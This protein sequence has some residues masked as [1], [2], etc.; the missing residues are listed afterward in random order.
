FWLVRSVPVCGQAP[1]N[2]RIVGG[3]ESSPGSWPWIVSIRPG[4][5]GKDHVCGGSLINEQWVL[6]ADI[7]L[8]ITVAGSHSFLFNSKWKNHTPQEPCFLF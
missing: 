4:E 2:T 6:T 7:G 1:L 8:K 3:Q 5:R